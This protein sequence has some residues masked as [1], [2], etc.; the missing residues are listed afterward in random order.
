MNDT[1]GYLLAAIAALTAT[2]VVLFKLLIGV[3]KESRV[4]SE[5]MTKEL[6]KNSLVIEN[7]TR[8]FDKVM[9]LV[10]KATKK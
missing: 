7:N 6:T 10:N 8:V 4:Q 5:A 3:M 2:V 1:V 9:E